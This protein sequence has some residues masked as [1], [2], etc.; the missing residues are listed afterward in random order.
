MS[1]QQ[2]CFDFIIGQ[3]NAV[4]YREEVIAESHCIRNDEIC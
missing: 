1:I 4:K 3:Y 2:F